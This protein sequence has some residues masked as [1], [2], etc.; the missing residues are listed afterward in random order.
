MDITTISTAELEYDLG[1]TKADIELCETAIHMGIY[2]YGSQDEHS[3]SE[4]LAVNKKIADKIQ[5]ELT[6]RGIQP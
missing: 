2:A 6:R 3:V 5:A 4:R 1:E